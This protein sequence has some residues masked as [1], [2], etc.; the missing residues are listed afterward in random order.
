MKSVSP[1]HRFVIESHS[2]KANTWNRTAD[3]PFREKPGHRGN[4][5][6]IGPFSP[7]RFI[8][9]LSRNTGI[10]AYPRQDET[11]FLRSSD[12]VAERE[13]FEPPVQVR[14]S[15]AQCVRK[16]QIA[17]AYNAHAIESL[18]RVHLQRGALPAC[19]FWPSLA[20]LRSLTS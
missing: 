5:V 19:K 8:R 15:K 9:E 1:H 20:A 18:V 7:F 13:G 6:R 3:A 14:S 11:Q 2:P 17:T 12:C 4:S 10:F 16:L